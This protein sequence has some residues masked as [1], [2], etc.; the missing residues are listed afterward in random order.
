MTINLAVIF[1]TETNGGGGFYQSLSTAKIINDFKN[2]NLK[3]VF[4]CTSENVQKVLFKH[5]IKSKILKI[6]Y[7]ERFI[8]II[9][10]K[11]FFSKILKKLRYRN[12]IHKISEKNKIDLF[13]FLGPSTLIDLVKN[14]EYSNFIVNIWDINHKLDNYFP[15]FKSIETFNQKEKVLKKVVNNSFKIIVNSKKASEDIEKFYNCNQKKISIIP[16]NTPL[17]N[18]SKNNNKEFYNEI[19]DNFEIDKKNKIFF[20]PAQYWPH[21]NHIYLFNVIK[22]LKKVNS[23]FI[24]ILTG[25]NKG[26]LEFLK[27][28]VT[29]YNLENYVKFYNFLNEDQIISLY[30]NSDALLMPTYVAR[31]TLPLLEAFYFN[32][33]VFYSKDVLDD[34]Y[35]E[36]VNEFDLNNEDDLFLQLKE[37]LDGETKYKSKTSAAKIFY[38]HLSKKGYLGLEKIF[39]EYKFLSSKW[40]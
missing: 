13:F 14:T 21:K 17:P 34:K 36:F 22:K 30:M 25:G 1:D 31:S 11:I 8:N 19:F 3:I 39:D 26:N 40:K 27:K 37:F 29:E 24:L 10:Q 7:F 16:F 28:K 20:Y 6:G 9:D 12:S 18:I 4:F 38:D 33:P 23:D 15:E 35:A 2:P 5:N 32:L